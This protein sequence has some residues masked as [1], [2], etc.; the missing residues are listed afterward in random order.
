MKTITV[1]IITKQRAKKLVRCIKS[2]QHQDAHPDQIVIIDTAETDELKNRVAKLGSITRIIY[3]HLPKASVAEAR[4]FAL[5][6]TKTNLLCFV[7]DD[8]IVSK[9]YIGSALDYFDRQTIP[10]KTAYIVGASKI[11]KNPSYAALAE[12]IYSNYWYEKKI[13]ENLPFLTPFNFDTKNVVLNL[14]TFKRNKVKFPKKFQLKSFDSSDTAVGFILDSLGLRGEQIK[15]LILWHD[16]GVNTLQLLT[17][18]FYKGVIAT[19]IAK[20]WHQSHEFVDLYFSLRKCMAWGNEYKGYL[21]ADVYQPF[22]SLKNILIFIIIK[23]R[24]WSFTA[25]YWLA[26]KHPKL[27]EKLEGSYF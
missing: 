20:R 15:H 26:T 12:Y 19:K 18:Q 16:D 27:I 21:Q 17:K 25:G 14:D 23:L 8:C 10:K 6:S 1:A 4:N 11:Y 2:L 5:D 13:Q 7:D 24:I 9:K 3:A 22:I